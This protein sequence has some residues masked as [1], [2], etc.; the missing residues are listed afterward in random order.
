MILIHFIK[1]QPR[2]LFTDVHNTFITV[3]LVKQTLHTFVSLYFY[4]DLTAFGSYSG[5][6]QVPWE[7]IQIRD[8]MS[9]HLCN[10][11]QV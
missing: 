2:A 5:R 11:V 3:I 8:Q 1:L 10:Q 4:I 7:F 9:E 6:A